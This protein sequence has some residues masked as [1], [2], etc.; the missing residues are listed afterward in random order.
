MRYRLVHLNAEYEVDIHKEQSEFVVR[1]RDKDYRISELVVQD[2]AISF[3]TEGK[4]HSIYF[5]RDGEKIY[6]TLD[7]EYYFIELSNRTRYGSQGEEQQKGNVIASSMPGL[8]VKLPVKVGDKVKSGDTLAI[9]EA[10]KMQNELRSPIDGEVKK[11]NCK[12][13]EQVD[14]FQT[15]VEIENATIK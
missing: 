8:L 11:I 12:E 3:R 15:I 2:N 5:A 14:A 10:M 7:G 4:R 1:I 13:G 9:V 6:V